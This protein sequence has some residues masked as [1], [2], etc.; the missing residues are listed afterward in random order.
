MGAVSCKRP[1]STPCFLRGLTQPAKELPGGAT[2]VPGSTLVPDPGWSIDAT[3]GGVRRQ[4][5]SPRAAGRGSV[6]GQRTGAQSKGSG[7]NV[8]RT[9]QLFHASRAAR[10]WSFPHA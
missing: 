6:Q 7:I 2:L 10:K 5:L 3:G 8:L 1:V 9:P 4:G